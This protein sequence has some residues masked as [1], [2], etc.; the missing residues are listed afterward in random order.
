MD[1]AKGARRNRAR[2][3][4]LALAA[5]FVCAAVPHAVAQEPAA[6]PFQ[7]GLAAYSEGRFGEAATLFE[8]SFAESGNRDALF[9]A[10]QAHRLSGDCERAIELYAKFK[11][12]DITPGQVEAVDQAMEICADQLERQ[13]RERQAR[14]AELERRNQQRIEEL[15]RDSKR[16]ALGWSLLATGGAATAAGVAVFVVARSNAQET[17]DTYEERLSQEETVRR[18][19]I[20]AGVLVGVGVGLLTAS[21]IRLVR[22]AKKGRSKETKQV[23][24]A[25]YT[26][27]F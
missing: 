3:G 1:Y 14:E 8:Q 27:E 25:L 21:V 20:T 13:E 22:K 12:G 9:A 19:R 2:V 24:G 5:Y 16:D 26:L 7:S 6:D 15:K 10:A 17:P 18:Q 11:I 23:A 4:A